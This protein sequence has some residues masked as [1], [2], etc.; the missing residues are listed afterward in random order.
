MPSMC[1]SKGEEFCRMIESYAASM[2]C[3]WAATAMKQAV[4]RPP[5]KKPNVTR[6]RKRARRERRVRRKE[7]FDWRT[8]NGAAKRR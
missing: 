3:P 4:I 1:V 8:A 5:T 7:H 2:E 6:E